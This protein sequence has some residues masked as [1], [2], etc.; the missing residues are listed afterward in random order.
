MR[1]GRLV[2]W[3]R[4][5]G[6]AGRLAGGQAGSRLGTGRAGG[7]PEDHPQ[8]L[9]EPSICF[10]DAGAQEPETRAQRKCL[11]Q[12]L[13]DLVAE[14][15]LELLRRLVSQAVAFLLGQ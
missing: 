2:T 3:D 7:S 5:L 13:K 10:P 4:P 9:G 15:D 6:A 14:K 1:W 11:L 8:L 12:E